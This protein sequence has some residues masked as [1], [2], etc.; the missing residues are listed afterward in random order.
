ML[1][2]GLPDP[3]GEHELSRCPPSSTPVL[4]PKLSAVRRQLGFVLLVG[5]VASSGCGSHSSSSVSSAGFVSQLNVLCTQGNA[6]VRAAPSVPAAATAFQSYL[7]RV[8]ALT[9]PGRFKPAFSRFTSLLSQRLAYV[10]QG[11]LGAARRLRQ[12]ISSLA[13]QLGAT[14][15]AH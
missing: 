4:I 5:L 13:H 12:P 10:R 2:H 1:R 8:Q 7:T 9:P 3:D 6:A 11:R 15:C 14:A